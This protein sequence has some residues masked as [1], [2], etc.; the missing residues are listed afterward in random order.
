MNESMRNDLRD[1]LRVAEE[2]N[3]ELTAF[4]RSLQSQGDN[5]MASMRN[6]IQQKI[7][8]DQQSVAK[9]N[10][11]SSILFNEMVRLGKEA[12]TLNERLG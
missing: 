5:E 8:E 2:S 6:F 10:E 7:S 9:T 1:R 4:M 11:K 12:E 3:K